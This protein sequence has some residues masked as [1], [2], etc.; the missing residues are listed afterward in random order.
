MKLRKRILSWM[1]ICLPL[2][3]AMSIQLNAQTRPCFDMQPKIFSNGCATSCAG[4]SV[5]L[6]AG[7]GYSSYYWS[8]GERS[9][10]IVVSS[11]E[12]SAQYW[13]ELSNEAGC[14]ARTEPM[15]VRINP[16]PA[17]P[18]IVQQD[19]VL[20]ATQA[21]HIT[22]MRNKVVLPYQ[23]QQSIV[24]HDSADYQIVVSD[25]NGCTASSEVVQTKAVAPGQTTRGRDAR[26]KVYPNPSAGNIAVQLISDYQGDISFT[27]TDLQGKEVYSGTWLQPK[28]LDVYHMDLSSLTDGAYMLQAHDG[29]D[30]VTA[31][32]IIQH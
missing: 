31:T 3:L 1:K 27:V 23:D 12:A 2:S 26:L 20:L 15:M 22:W 25:E 24:I 11:P 16:A 4:S 14:R 17:K 6:D 19:S 18:Y 29:V 9:Q 5:I 28:V 13:C 21:V 10:R 7:P 32:I 8:N 30:V